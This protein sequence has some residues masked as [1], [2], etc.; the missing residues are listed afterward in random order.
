MNNAFT[1]EFR[2][3]LI[4]VLPKSFEFQVFSD[5]TLV[6]ELPGL[7]LGGVRILTQKI[8]SGTQAV[9]VRFSKALGALHSLLAPGHRTEHHTLEALE[10]TAAQTLSALLQPCLHLLDADRDLI[11]DPK[12]SDQVL[13]RL[14][15]L[16][17]LRDEMGFFSYL[18]QRFIENASHTDAPGSDTNGAFVQNITPQSLAY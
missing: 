2:E 6:I 16:D 10:T 5:P 12:V 8:W 4:K 13:A 7:I 15:R 14:E 1:D 11:Q 18:L 17:S 3:N 9:T